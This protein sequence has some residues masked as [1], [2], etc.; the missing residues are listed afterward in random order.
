MKPTAPSIAG[1]IERPGV[2]P[3]ETIRLGASPRLVPHLSHEPVVWW[4]RQC[5]SCN[6]SF[7]RNLAV[8]PID[9]TPLK[10]VEVSLPFLWIG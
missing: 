9:S 4:E 6:H 7:T 5:P 1:T 2:E 3:E 10:R 8:C